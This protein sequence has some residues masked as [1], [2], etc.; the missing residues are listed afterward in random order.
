[1]NY[2]GPFSSNLVG[3]PLDTLKPSQMAKP[4]VL[5]GTWNYVNESKSKTMPMI[6]SEISGKIVYSDYGNFTLTVPNHSGF[7]DYTLQGSWGYVKPNVLTECYIGGC[8]NNILK[9]L[10]PNHVEFVDNRGDIIH[11]MKVSDGKT[12]TIKQVS[13]FCTPVHLPVGVWYNWCIF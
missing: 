11:L 2:T 13:V 10:T 4:H 6:S 3:C 12:S 1:M 5:V 7:G 9:T 8:E